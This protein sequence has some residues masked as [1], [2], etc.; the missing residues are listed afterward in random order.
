MLDIGSM[1]GDLL[2]TAHQF[3]KDLCWFKQNCQNPVGSGSPRRM[4]VGGAKPATE[5]TFQQLQGES[6]PKFWPPAVSNK[7][8]GTEPEFL[9]HY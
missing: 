4:G 8:S 5:V 7:I 6:N 3:L 9:I 2:H 1:N